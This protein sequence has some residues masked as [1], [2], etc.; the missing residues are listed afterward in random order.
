MTARHLRLTRDGG[1]VPP[2]LL[3]QR[4]ERIG[5]VPGATN[6]YHRGSSDQNTTSPPPKQATAAM[7]T[8]TMALV[9][10]P[11]QSSVRAEGGERRQGVRVL[12]WPAQ[13]EAHRARRTPCVRPL[14]LQEFREAGKNL[15][16]A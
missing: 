13:E 12:W 11:P 9:E 7:P 6:F 1:D 8:T 5:S 2:V 10:R 4:L 15:G 14:K 3:E 16:A